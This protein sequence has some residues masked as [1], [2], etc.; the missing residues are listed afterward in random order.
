MDCIEVLK[1]FKAPIFDLTVTSP[2]YDS[3]REYDTYHWNESIWK[4]IIA[5]LYKTTKPGG[6]VVW[7]VGD[8]T[9]N[10]SETGTSF[11]Q[12]LFAKECGFL[13]YDTMIYQKAGVV[14]PD[15]NRYYSNFEYMFIWSKGKP[16][17]FNPIEDKPNSNAGRK[18]SG[19]ERQPDGT[20]VE[21]VGVKKGREIKPVGRRYNVWQYTAGWCHSYNEE[22][23]K[24][25]PA[26]MPKEL[27][28]DH[29]ISWSNPND[30]VFDPFAGSGTTLLAAKE[31]KRMAVGTEVSEKYCEIIKRRLTDVTTNE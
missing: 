23:L 22:Y 13:L 31:L 3:L 18:V 16:K 19:G 2:P 1:H 20:I 26:I 6:V 21:R 15:A 17:A 10:G 27:A 7:I 24:G 29:I 5:L 8:M 11:K 14:F 12:A 30:V 28:K 4:E 9:I 25:H